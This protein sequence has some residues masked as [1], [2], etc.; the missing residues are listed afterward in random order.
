MTTKNLSEETEQKT[1]NPNPIE[2]ITFLDCHRLAILF[3]IYLQG[4]IV[5]LKLPRETSNGFFFL[6]DNF[7]L[8][9]TSATNKMKMKIQYKI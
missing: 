7:H 9:H 5:I 8:L 2:V 6:S 1:L 4:A 3:K